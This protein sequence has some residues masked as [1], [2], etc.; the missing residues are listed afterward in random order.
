MGRPAD[1]ER[2]GNRRIAL[3]RLDKMIPEVMDELQNMLRSDDKDD[4]KFAI[5]MLTDKF[6]PQQKETTIDDKREKPA[7]QEQIEKYLEVSKN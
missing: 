6:L 2:L 5:K 1:F 7:L 4:K 3:Q